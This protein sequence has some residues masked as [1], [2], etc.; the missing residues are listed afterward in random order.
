M[1]CA[2]FHALCSSTPLG[3]C[4]TL[5]NRIL[6]RNELNYRV[7]TLTSRDPSFSRG[8]THNMT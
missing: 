1:G 7:R 3:V 8:Q 6:I 4:I 5:Q 2:C